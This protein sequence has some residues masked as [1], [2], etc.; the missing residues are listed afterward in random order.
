MTPKKIIFIHL[1]ND[2]SGS[3]KVLSQVI[4]TVQSAAFEVELYT[5]KSEDGFLSDLNILHHNYFYN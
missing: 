2:Y 1:V 3:P 4:G 5:A